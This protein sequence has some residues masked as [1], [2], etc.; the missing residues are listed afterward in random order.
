M[1]KELV[2][3]TDGGRTITLRA[4]LGDRVRAADIFST[5]PL[6]ASNNLIT[7]EDPG[8]IVAAQQV[9]PLIRTNTAGTQGKDIPRKASRMP[10]TADLMQLNEKVSEDA[11]QTP[12]V[13][14][15]PG[16][17]TKASR[18]AIAWHVRAQGA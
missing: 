11:K 7:L 8:D 12:G 9:L 16:S 10:R 2:P 14:Q 6:I 18:D 15:L 1:P 13:L 5:P 4:L 3:F 17:R